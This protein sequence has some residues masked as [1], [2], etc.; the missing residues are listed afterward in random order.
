MG[1]EP[2]LPASRRLHRPEGAARAR[3]S[4]RRY[5]SARARAR[6]LG[7]REPRD[8]DRS[9]LPIDRRPAR[10]DRLHAR[11]SCRARGGRAL[12]P[13][14]SRRGGAH[15]RAEALSTREAEGEIR[16]F[17]Q[18]ERDFVEEA[19]V[20]VVGSGPSG[21]VV[22]Y[23]LAKAGHRV[24]LVEEGPPFTPKDFRIDGNVSMA[25]T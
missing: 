15:V 21:S 14:A 13:A 1:R 10:A 20:V 16:V 22:T 11:G 7:D 3:L 25:R 24:L 8:R 18:Y 17:A 5:E 2:A 6:A 9:D 19:D 12:G 4:R 23:E